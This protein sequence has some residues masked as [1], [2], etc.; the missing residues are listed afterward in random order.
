MSPG[1]AG[2]GLV[3]QHHVLD[4]RAAQEVRR[5]QACLTPAD[6]DNRDAWL[7]HTKESCMRSPALGLLSTAATD[8]SCAAAYRDWE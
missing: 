7:V 6:D 5:R 4:P 1:T 2:R 8:P 3:V